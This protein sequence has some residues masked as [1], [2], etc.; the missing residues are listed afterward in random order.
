MQGLSADAW[1]QAQIDAAVA[2]YVGRLP[3][4]EIAWMRERLAETLATEP[5]AK[6]LA[7]RARPRPVVDESGEVRVGPAAEVGQSA[8]AAKV[9]RGRAG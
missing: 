6:D 3:A 1:I 4:A 8:P 9:P 7:A 5:R 2:P